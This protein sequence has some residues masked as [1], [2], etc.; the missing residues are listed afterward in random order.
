MM[1]I[2]TGSRWLY[3][4]LVT[5]IISHGRASLRLQQW[6]AFNMC[7]SCT[8]FCVCVYYSNNIQF[9]MMIDDLSFL[10]GWSA[11][12]SGFSPCNGWWWTTSSLSLNDLCVYAHAF[13]KGGIHTRLDTSSQFINY[14]KLNQYSLYSIIFSDDVMRDVESTFIFTSV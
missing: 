5:T 13:T 10:P 8:V 12:G 4:S 9:D 2:S 6:S 7:T 3:K 14:L 11:N 1:M